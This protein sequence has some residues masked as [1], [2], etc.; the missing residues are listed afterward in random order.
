MHCSKE[1][2]LAMLSLKEK[3]ASFW[4]SDTPEVLCQMFTGYICKALVTLCMC[5]HYMW[6]VAKPDIERECL[7]VGW[8]HSVWE[9]CL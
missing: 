9:H 5:K 2:R 1:K 3:E 6:R 8:N 7:K 4:C